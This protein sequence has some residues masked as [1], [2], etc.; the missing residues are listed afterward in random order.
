MVSLYAKT[1]QIITIGSS[2]IMEF[3]V[4]K[5]LMRLS[6]W[7]LSSLVLGKKIGKPGHLH[8]VSSLYG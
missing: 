1:F 8:D 7:D 3:I 2:L 4:A 6:L 5:L